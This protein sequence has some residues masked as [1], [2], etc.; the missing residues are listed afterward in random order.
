MHSKQKEIAEE[1]A[2]KRM[3]EIQDLGKQ[4]D[5]DNLTYNLIKFL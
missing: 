5:F 2:N 4:T 1:L 3:K